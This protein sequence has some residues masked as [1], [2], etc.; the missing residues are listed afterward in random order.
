MMPTKRYNAHNHDAGKE[1]DERRRH[2]AAAVLVP[3]ETG[4]PLRDALA[5]V[6]VHVWLSSDR[7]ERRVVGARQIRFKI[8]RRLLLLLPV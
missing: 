6:A 2:Q 5:L 3:V 4:A 1:H 8:N 7:L